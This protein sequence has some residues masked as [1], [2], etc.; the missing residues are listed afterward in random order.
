MNLVGDIP[1]VITDLIQGGPHLSLLKGCQLARKVADNQR[2]GI[3]GIACK[4]KKGSGGR[5]CKGWKGKKSKK[6]RGSCLR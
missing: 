3:T 6:K 2:K 1:E 5:E 4:G